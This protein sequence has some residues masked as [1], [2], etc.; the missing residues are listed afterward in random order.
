MISYGTIL[1]P[2]CNLVVLY[3]LVAEFNSDTYIQIDY[4]V[5]TMYWHNYFDR[6]LLY[7][8][9]KLQ[10]EGALSEHHIN[11]CNVQ[12]SNVAPHIHYIYQCVHV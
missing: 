5:A 4:Q 12:L 9:N 7:M 10:V 11:V 8:F 1:K 2:G 6:V 3:K